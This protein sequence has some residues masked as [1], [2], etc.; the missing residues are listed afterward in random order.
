MSQ[1]KDHM[2]SICK[3]SNKLVGSTNFLSWKKRIDLALTENEVMEYVLGGVVVPDKEKTQ[4]LA[5]YKKGEVRA[6]KIIVES[7]KDHLVPFVVDLKTSKAMYDKLV[8]LYSIST[9]GQ[10]ISLRNQLYRI[11]KSKDEDM[12]TYL[13]KISQIRDQ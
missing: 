4:E 12:A 8:K 7:I 1:S 2:A 13:M 10:N 6:Q 5:K 9:S 3:E 11:M